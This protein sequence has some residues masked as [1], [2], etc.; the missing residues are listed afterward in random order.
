[1]FIATSFQSIFVQEVV[2]SVIGAALKKK[3]PFLWVT[4]IGYQRPWGARDPVTLGGG[5]GR[6]MDGVVSDV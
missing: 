5:W 2:D 4:L 3:T 6:K 1:M